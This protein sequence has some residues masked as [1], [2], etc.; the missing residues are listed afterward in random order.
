MN[1]VFHK[2]GMCREVGLPRYGEQS[3]GVSPS[4]AQDQ[5]SFRSG[6]ILLSN[7][8]HTEGLEFIA[9]P[10]L[11]FTKKTYFC[12]VGAAYGEVHLND[13]V[14]E[15]GRVYLADKGEV[16]SFKKKLYGFRTYLCTKSFENNNVAELVGRTRGNFKELAHW[17][18]PKGKIRIMRGPEFHL[19]ENGD[20]FLNQALEISREMSEMGLKLEGNELLL[21]KQVNMISSPVALGTVQLSPSGPIILMRECQTVGG[22]PRVFSVISADLDLLAQMNPGQKIDFQLVDQSEAVEC[23]KQQE[24]DLRELK[25]KFENN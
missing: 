17:P 24:I 8:E 10:V 6:N 20:S 5:F 13:Q 2:L 14:I 25:R 23:L 11:E 22:Y 9:P 15:H 4:G 12:L 16:L 3:R 19:L 21:K 18:E 1:F 7:D